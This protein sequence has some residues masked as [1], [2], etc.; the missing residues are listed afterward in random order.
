MTKDLFLISSH[1][2]K[3]VLALITSN[4]KKKKASNDGGL[5][6]FPSNLP[7]TQSTYKV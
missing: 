3:Y 7:Y 2:T 6:T 5:T 1:Q 4:E